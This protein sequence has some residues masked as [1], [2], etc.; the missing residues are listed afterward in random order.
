MLLRHKHGIEVPERAFDKAICWHLG[1]AVTSM[2]AGKRKTAIIAAP[3][4][5]EDLPEL[6]PDFQ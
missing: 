5:E 3:H 4:I 1:E 2:S 6:F